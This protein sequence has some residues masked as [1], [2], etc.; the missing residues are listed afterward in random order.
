M[1]S[2]TKLCRFLIDDRR[3]TVIL[4]RWIGIDRRYRPYSPVSESA[5][6]VDID[7][8][9]STGSINRWKGVDIWIGVGT[10]SH[11]TWD[12]DFLVDLCPGPFLTIYGT[13][14]QWSFFPTSRKNAVDWF[15]LVWI[16]I[17]GRFPAT[18]FWLKSTV[19]AISTVFFN[20][21]VGIDRR[22]RPY[23]RVGESASTVDIDRIFE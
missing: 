11:H 15:V 10:I 8:D 21:L 12:H 3:S 14:G 4:R 19:N 2:T 1:Q 20:R 23:F 6:T 5:S 9:R 17:D 18:D 16:Y 22:Y 7:C 13:I